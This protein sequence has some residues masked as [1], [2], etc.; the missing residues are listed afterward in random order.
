MHPYWGLDVTKSSW[1]IKK[2]DTTALP[3]TVAKSH[4][5]ALSPTKAVSSICCLLPVWLMNAGSC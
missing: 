1:A 3:I 5:D 4:P 2:K